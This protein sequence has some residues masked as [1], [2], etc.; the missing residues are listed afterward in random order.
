MK[1][2]GFTVKTGDGHLLVTGVQPEGK[3][4]MDAAE[5]ILGRNLEPGKK[6]EAA[7]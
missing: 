7:K 1:G 4:R 6:L 3:R 2:F 5:Y